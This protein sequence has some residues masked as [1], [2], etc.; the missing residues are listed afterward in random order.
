MLRGLS[1][2]SNWTGDIIDTVVL[3]YEDR[4]RRRIAL[5]GHGGTHFLLDLPTVPSIRDGDA[6]VLDSKNM[7]LVRAA[8]EALMTITTDD[9]IHLARIA[10][11]VGNRH[12]A[13]EIFDGGLR[14]R[15]DHVI[16]KMI[17]GLGGRITNAM[18]PFNPEGGAY[19]GNMP[20]QGHSHGVE[21]NHQG[22][23]VHNDSHLHVHATGQD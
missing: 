21:H 23:E 10:W 22:S 8:P 5:E 11:H 19:G 17:E 16:A 7:V 4:H 12:L 9:P 3:N 15:S 2:V 14:I 1:I 6:I 20:V 13:A 18:A